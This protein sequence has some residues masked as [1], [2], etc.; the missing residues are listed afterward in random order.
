MCPCANGAVKAGNG[1]ASPLGKMGR[2]VMPTIFEATAFQNSLWLFIGVVAGALI[3]HLLHRINLRWQ[4]NTAF[5]ILKSEIDLNLDALAD[6]E[7]RV[8]YLKERITASQV[9]PDELFV[10]MGQ[11]DYSAMSPLV[12]QGFFHTILGPQLVKKYFSFSRLF[13]NS[14]ASALSSDLRL[15]H[16]EGKSLDFLDGILGAISHAR[17]DM[18]MIRDAKLPL[19]GFRLRAK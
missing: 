17:S 1:H 8:Q 15:K 2:N 5:D 19:I 16:E 11:F 13:N 9:D 12:N 6:L 18:I 4:R 10:S 7:R 3:Q 14:V